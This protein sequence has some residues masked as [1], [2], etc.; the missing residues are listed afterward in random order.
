MRGKCRAGSLEGGSRRKSSRNACFLVVGGL[1]LVAAVGSICAF[2]RH[3]GGNADK[4]LPPKSAALSA[5]SASS[6]LAPQS[7]KIKDDQAHFLTS[8]AFEN[9]A[10]KAP[11]KSEGAT[12][13]EDLKQP[14][15]L[16]ELLALPPAGLDKVD[17]ALMN[18]LSAEGLRGAETV[19]VQQLL[20]TLDSWAR[21]VGI[22]TKHHYYRFVKDP[23]F[24]N[25]SE[26]DFRM[27]F[28]AST[29]Q[30]QFGL[31]YN[32]ERA[33]PQLRDGPFA[34]PGEVFF[35]DSKDVFIHG[36]LAGNHYGTCSSMPVLFVAV[37]QR[38]GYPVHLAISK[39]HLLV[40]YE[41]GDHHFN[42]EATSPGYAV[43]QDEHYKN[44]PLP[45]S[46][47]EVKNE[48]YFQPLNGRETLA[49]F[50]SIRAACLTAAGHFEKAREAASI[51]HNLGPHSEG[52]T[53]MQEILAEKIENDRKADRWDQLI[54]ELR[55]IDPPRDENFE[56]F[57]NKK[58]ALQLH[59]AT[60]GDL[61]GAQ[62]GVAALQRELA[63]RKKAD[64]S[65]PLALSPE[66]SEPAATVEIVVMPE[67]ARYTAIN[68]QTF[69]TLVKS[70]EQLESFFREQ[71]ILDKVAEIGWQKRAGRG[72]SEAPWN[73]LRPASVEVEMPPGMPRQV[74]LRM[75]EEELDEILQGQEAQ[76]DLSQVIDPAA[77][78]QSA[79]PKEAQDAINMINSINEINRQNRSGGNFPSPVVPGMEFLQHL[80]QAQKMQQ[81][82]TPQPAR[83]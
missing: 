24:F 46:D 79:I 81:I 36:L 15:T 62:E 27:A 43:Y 34:E 68:G 48:H 53:K 41:E 76:K 56:Y 72:L 71:R 31:R 23:K 52:Y 55:K 40:R 44:W 63:A 26:G 80:Q 82:P 6:G 67:K 3:A 2:A 42:V 11:S 33:A 13:V 32:P 45:T 74:R 20:K 57:R 25:D 75:V 58:I 38:L 77:R 28:L 59:L 35:A 1:L 17:I 7:H 50:L 78:A 83:H 51:A 10:Q 49:A 66:S 22:N 16:A 47:E 61:D 70:P 5:E 39:G 12:K 69:E 65:G 54:A 21:W 37:A 8:A 18:L 14:K 29:L 73:A 4:A 60:T 9:D 19:D 30:Q 64:A